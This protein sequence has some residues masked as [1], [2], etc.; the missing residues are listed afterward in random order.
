MLPSGA[1]AKM[2]MPNTSTQDPSILLQQYQQMPLH[3]QPLLQLQATQSSP[4]VV[5]VL[6]PEEQQQVVLLLESA[7]QPPQHSPVNSAVEMPGL[8]EHQL[9]AGS[10]CAAPA[11]NCLQAHTFAGLRAVDADAWVAGSAAASAAATIRAASAGAAPAGMMCVSQAQPAMIQARSLSTASSGSGSP[12][13]GGSG[14]LSELPALVR[15]LGASLQ[16]LRRLFS[17]GASDQVQQPVWMVVNLQVSESIHDA[18]E[19]AWGKE[20]AL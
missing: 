11:A 6:P 4:L 10:T 7:K 16:S 12:G 14:R 19:P 18:T 3:P 20:E 8:A 2:Q 1:S 9:A 5:A 17:G 13:P 15:E